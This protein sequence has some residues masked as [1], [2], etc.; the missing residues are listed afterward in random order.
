MLNVSKKKK[1]KKREIKTHLMTKILEIVHILQDKKVKSPQR[2]RHWLSYKRTKNTNAEERQSLEPS[3]PAVRWFQISPPHIYFAHF[4]TYR[5]IVFPH[6]PCKFSFLMNG[7]GCVW[8]AGLFVSCSSFPPRPWVGVNEA[9]YVLPCHSLRCLL[10]MSRF[11]RE[12]K[13]L[14]RKSCPPTPG[15]HAVLAL[16]LTHTHPQTHTF[17]LVSWK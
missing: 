10:D 5:H 3:A 13:C 17:T 1:I 2:N 9:L 7:W 14:F 12:L 15:W 6:I 11:V 8:A 16:S 4:M